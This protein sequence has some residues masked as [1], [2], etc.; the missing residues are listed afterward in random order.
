MLAARLLDPVFAQT[1]KP[2]KRTVSYARHQVRRDRIAVNPPMHSVASQT[3][4]AAVVFIFKDTLLFFGGSEGSL[5]DRR[6]ITC[7]TSGHCFGT[8]SFIGSL[9]SLQPDCMN[10]DKRMQRRSGANRESGG[11][12]R[13]GEPG[14]PGGIWNVTIPLEAEHA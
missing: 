3:C 1:P 8:D 13:D 7:R 12:I 9:A 5:V 11:E 4:P 2:L 6:I 14:N 10:L